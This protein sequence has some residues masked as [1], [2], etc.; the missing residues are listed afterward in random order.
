MRKFTCRA[1]SLDEE[2]SKRRELLVENVG[3]RCDQEI[4]KWLD[5]Y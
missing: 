3:D 1:M 4:G 5:T 2:V